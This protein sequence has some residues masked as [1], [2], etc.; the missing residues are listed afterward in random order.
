MLSSSSMNSGEEGEGVGLGVGDVGE[1]MRLLLLLLH[2]SFVGGRSGE[3]WT[4]N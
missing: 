1:V 3:G 4:F 2:E